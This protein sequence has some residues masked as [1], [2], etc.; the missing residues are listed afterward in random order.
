VAECRNSSTIITE[1]L[2]RRNIKRKAFNCLRADARSQTVVRQ[3]VGQTDGQI[4]GQSRQPI[5]LSKNLQHKILSERTQR[6]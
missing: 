1:G 2:Q 4:D 3:R 5:N 6:F